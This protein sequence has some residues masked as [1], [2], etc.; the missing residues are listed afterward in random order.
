MMQNK[1]RNMVQRTIGVPDEI[2][3]AALAMMADDPDM[4]YSTAIRKILRAGMRQIESER[5]IR[6]GRT[7]L[8]F[9]FANRIRE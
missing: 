6:E 5:D 9:D 7:Q 8:N 4:S 1:E 3:Q 2:D